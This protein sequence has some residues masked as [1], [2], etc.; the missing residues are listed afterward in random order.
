MT[1]RDTLDDAKSGKT[2]R[3]EGKFSPKWLKGLDIEVATVIDVGVH[4]GTP[5][6]YRGFP[7][8]K[9]VLIDPAP[10]CADQVKSRFPK[11]DMAFHR[12]AAGR[13]A[14][15]AEFSVAGAASTLNVEADGVKRDIVTL[16][17]KTQ[18][19]IERLDTLVSQRLFRAFRRQD[20]RRRI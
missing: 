13:A 12:I 9:L 19:T 14:G 10:D 15:T 5:E 4:R 20:R 16:A 7:H 1:G 6:L 11:L 17:P 8:A 18:V 2:K 3:P